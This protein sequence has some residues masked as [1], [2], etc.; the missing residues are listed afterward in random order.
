MSRN[1]AT[2][3]DARGTA[4]V[5]CTLSRADLSLQGDRW[6][7]LRARAGAGRVPTAEGLRMHFRRE[8]GVEEELD[9]L[10]ARERGCCSWADWSVAADA[11]EIVLEV[12]ASGEGIN[13][14][15][16]MFLDPLPNAAA[17]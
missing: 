16:G 17:S 1:D 3:G 5:A 6:M 7:K 4:V 11:E 9:E 10:V 2:T 13:A 15:H 14:L 8:P 12:R